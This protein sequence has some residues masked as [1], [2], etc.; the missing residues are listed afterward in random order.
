M[1]TGRTEMTYEQRDVA[2]F[3]PRRGECP[4]HRRQVALMLLRSAQRAL[5]GW[6]S[7]GPRIIS[8][9]FRTSKENINM[10]IIQCYA[11]TNESEEEAKKEFHDRR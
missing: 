6:E 2:I 8:A 4:T 7:H 1:D 9:S 5:L 10:N 3:G 11:P